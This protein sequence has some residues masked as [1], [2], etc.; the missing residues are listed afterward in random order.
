M[1]APSINPTQLQPKRVHY[2]KPQLLARL[3]DAQHEVDLWGRGTGK[4]Q[5][6]LSVRALDMAQQMPRCSFVNVANTYMQLLD[7]T[8]PPMVAHWQELGMQR[9]VDFWIR[10]FPD[11]KFG[12]KMPYIMPET[13]DHCVF[14]RANKDSVSLMRLVSQDRPASASGMSVDGIIGDEARYLNYQKIQDELIPTNR[15]NDRYFKGKHLHH[16]TC[17]MSDMPNTSGS[18]WLIEEEKKMDNEAVALIKAIQVHLSKIAR[19]AKIRGKFTKA[20]LSQLAFYQKELYKLRKGLT[21]YSEASTLE[22]IG[23]LGLDFI[24][25]M[26]RQLSPTEFNRAILNLRPDSVEEGFYPF[27]ADHHFYEDAIEYS[28][29]D[30]FKEDKYGKGKLNDCRKD[31]DIN[32]SIPLCIAPDFG[33]SFNCLAVGQ[34]NNMDFNILKNFYVKNPK[35]VKDLGTDFDKYYRYFYKKEVTMYFDHTHYQ[36]NPVSEKVPKDELKAELVAR[37]WRV[38]ERFVG[39]TPSYFH[40]H[41]LWNA[42]L[43]GDDYRV[44]KARFNKYNTE[45]IRNSMQNTAIKRG[46]KDPFAK[47]K[48]L[49]KKLDADQLDAPHLSD[50]ADILYYGANQDFFQEFNIPADAYM[51]GR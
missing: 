12:L 1:A 33:G 5:G 45:E 2:N 14:I 32:R 6:R 17:Y 11:K 3:I 40:R 19:N 28:F 42:G 27:L 7:R 37:G 20:D 22:N 47:D 25:L 10:K 44:L 21:Y 16:S 34:R 18:K 9:D 43:A 38:Y 50:A 15:G 51:L 46:G 41:H 8:L 13:P 35:R 29:V 23:V 48:A 4:S 36:K 39:E 26:S 31:S 30:G 49:E 24:K